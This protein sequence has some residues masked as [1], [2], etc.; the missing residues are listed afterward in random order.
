MYSLRLQRAN[1]A[2][3]SSVNILFVYVR[4]RWRSGQLQNHHEYKMQRKTTAPIMKREK[5]DHGMW[6]TWYNRN[7]YFETGNP[8]ARGHLEEVSVDEHNMARILNRI[9]ECVQDS[10]GSE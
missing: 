3:Y 2:Q 4:N 5:D 10:F 9:S 1:H 8:K 7:A 6:R